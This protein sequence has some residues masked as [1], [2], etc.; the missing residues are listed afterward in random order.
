MVDEPHV[1]VL[2]AQI[3]ALLVPERGGNDQRLIVDATL[4]AAGHAQQLLEAMGPQGRLIGLDRDPS[5]L[6]IARK[7]LEAYGDR[8]AYVPSP[9][10]DL[11]EAVGAQDW[12]KA[13]GVL[14]DLGIS[15]MHV[16]EASRGFAFRHDALLDMRM[17]PTQTL[18]AADVV[19]TYSE[20]D[21]TRIIREY[22]EE[23]WAARI[24]K[25]IVARRRRIPLSTTLELVD[26]IR[27]AVPS[28]ARRGGPHPARRTFQ[29]L[30]IEV[31]AELEQ[32]QSSLPQALAVTREGGRLVAVSYHSLEDRIVKR[33]F[34][35]EASGETPRLRILT[36]KPVR[37]GDEEM[38]SNPRSTSALMRA[39]EVLAAPLPDRGFDGSAA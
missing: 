38:R 23:R 11:E 25:F 14:W 24:A 28:A 10:G 21:L 22:G 13:D 8:V 30:R 3:I 17:D 35:S 27:A 31:N 20:S 26:V 5:A 7:R 18:T 33:F 37:P 34:K 29:A 4:G 6:Q 39:A 19:N 32:L 36:K 9:F 2:A 12:G 1:P 16:D 15:S